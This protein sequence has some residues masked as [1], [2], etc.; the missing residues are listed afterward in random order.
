MNNF[1]RRAK[2]FIWG[3]LCI[4]LAL[5]CSPIPM[6]ISY[7]I[8]TRD[9]A[10]FWI[11]IFHPSTAWL[12]T[13][14]QLGLVVGAPIVFLASWKIAT[15]RPLRIY[16]LLVWPLSWGLFASFVG[17][18]AGWLQRRVGLMDASVR[19]IP[20]IVAIENYRFD[21]GK[22]PAKL[23]DLM[24]QYLR[25]IPATGMAAH[26]NFYYYSDTKRPEGATFHS[27]EVGVQTPFGLSFDRFYYWPENNYP[28]T[29]RSGRVE[30]IGDWAYLHE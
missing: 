6:S 27:Y 8:S 3:A 12:W 22:P 11:G 25:A 17:S 4:L 5:I 7:A 26:P 20:L 18:N 2:P 15:L 23:S 1:W 10:P 16:A 14:A 28:K 24:P 30:R 13:V 21:N 19:A 29:S 9:V